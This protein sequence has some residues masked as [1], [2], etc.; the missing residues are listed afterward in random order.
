MVAQFKI[1]RMEAVDLNDILVSTRDCE[2][3]LMIRSTFWQGKANNSKE[4]FSIIPRY[5]IFVTGL[6]PNS[7]NLRQNLNFVTR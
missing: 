3:S 5:S 7:P 4:E 1:P 2:Q 6:E